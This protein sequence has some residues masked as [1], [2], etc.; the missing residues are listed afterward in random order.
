MED[1]VETIFSIFKMANKQ[2]AAS[3]NEKLKYIS[4][5]I[6]NYVC[7]M[8]KDNKIDIKTLHDKESSINMQP[9]FDYIE[10]NNIELYNFKIIEMS[11]VD[12]NSSKDIERF[13]LSHIYY[14]TQ[15]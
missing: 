12:I 3:S 4:M 1:F 5:I 6:Y 2:A 14:I 8:A 13:V 7:K 15:K 9:F 10:Y 11:D